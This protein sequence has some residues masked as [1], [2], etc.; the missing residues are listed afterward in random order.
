MAFRLIPAIDTHPG[1]ISFA[2]TKLG[3]LTVVGLFAF[4]FYII[5]R[6]YWDTF[7]LM[8]TLLAATFL[9][10]YRRRIVTIATLSWLLISTPDWFDWTVPKYIAEHY[11]MAGAFNFLNLER[12]AIVVVLSLS[13]L[14]LVFVY[15]HPKSP[16]A[17]RPLLTLTVLYSG[18]LA[19][20]CYGLP[21]REAV[22]AWSIVVT[23]G[24]LF[25]FLGYAMLDHQNGD[26]NSVGVQMG[27]FHPFWGSSTTPIP[28]GAAYLRRVESKNAADLA[29][30][31]LKALKLILW[32]ALLSVCYSY[33]VKTLHHLLHLPTFQ[34]AFDR[35]VARAPYPWYVCWLVV[36]AAFFENLFVLSVWGHTYV[37]CCRMAGF[38]A[39]RNTYR[40]LQAKTI[41][42]FWNR[43]YFYFKELMVD[44][45]FYPTFFRYF[46]GH[47]R[48]RIAAATFM[49]AGFGNL[50]FHFLRDIR[51]VAELGLRKALIGYHVYAFYCLVLSTGIAAS[52]LRKKPHRGKRYRFWAGVSPTF[53]VLAFYCLLQVFDDTG[54]THPITAHFTFLL[55][56][57]GVR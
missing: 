3:K 10:Q 21:G 16:L 19:L 57:F 41:A 27:T 20:A 4:G 14:M 29:I 32:A 49:A 12:A 44:F 50:F 13:A 37:A 56:L 23:V 7:A 55:H 15:R 26:R 22:V 30:T 38:R 9:P 51:Y 43:Y 35:S 6:S 39:L 5:Q 34:D 2:Q 25:W 52:Q 46:K 48:L 11:R 53:G 31:Q 24:A 47:R 33:W 28:K 17:R 54:R 45:F 40:P 36:T 1:N 8:A 18:L 42:E